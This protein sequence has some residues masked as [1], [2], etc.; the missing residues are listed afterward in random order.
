MYRLLPIEL[1]LLN[2]CKILIIIC[3]NINI[4]LLKQLSQMYISRIMSRYE[5]F[6][7]LKY[8]QISYEIFLDSAQKLVFNGNNSS[9]SVL[10]EDL[11]ICLETSG[12]KSKKLDL[13][14]ALFAAII[15][16]PTLDLR[17][18]KFRIDSYLKKENDSAFTGIYHAA[19]SYLYTVYAQKDSAQINYALA[20][21]QLKSFNRFKSSLF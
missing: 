4:L 6:L 2:Q 1:C 8:E 3:I 17:S 21:E 13:Y 20:I 18:K 15:Q 5:E 12:K 10:L 16:D 7:L 19:Q 14:E 11:Q 9:A